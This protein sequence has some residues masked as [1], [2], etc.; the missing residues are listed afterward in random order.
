MKPR[1]KYYMNIA[2]TIKSI[3]LTLQLIYTHPFLY[4]VSLYLLHRFFTRLLIQFAHGNAAK[5]KIYVLYY[6]ILETIAL[7]SYDIRIL[8]DDTHIVF[9]F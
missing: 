5:S 6:N 7:Q 1:I 2:Y 3:W 4:P 8:F 9:V